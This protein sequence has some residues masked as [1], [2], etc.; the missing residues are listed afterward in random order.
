V[1]TNPV[2]YANLQKYI[3]LCDAARAAR[4]GEF[5]DSMA[6]W[7]LARFHYGTAFSMMTTPNTPHASCGN[8]QADNG[9]LASRS[10]HPGGVNTLFGDGSVRFVK[11]SVNQQTWWSLGTK[12]GGE[13]VSADSY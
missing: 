7:S 11:N 12:S 1:A 3:P 6:Y 10:R 5:N 2:G 13:V 4:K 8:Y 9:I